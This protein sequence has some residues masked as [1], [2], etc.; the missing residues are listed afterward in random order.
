MKSKGEKKVFRVSADQQLLKAKFKIDS[1]PH[2]SF[3][4]NNQI[5]SEIEQ[6]APNDNYDDINKRLKR[7]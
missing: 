6:F 2:I 5:Y 4:E 1:E 7:K 3:E